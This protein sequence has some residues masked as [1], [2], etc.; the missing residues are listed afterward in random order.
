[1]T[2]T[3]RPETDSQVAEAVAW[4]AAEEVPLELRGRGSKRGLGR[5]PQAG[6]ALD[7]SGL[8]G[9]TL[10]EPEELVL[11]AWAGTPLAEIEAA[12]AEKNQALAFEPADLGPLLGG[13]AGAGSIG[14]YSSLPTRRAGTFGPA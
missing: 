2:E 9:I 6:Q 7:L 11:A 14:G 13:A 10:Y 4:A 8:T 12:L 3:L 5:P 1:M